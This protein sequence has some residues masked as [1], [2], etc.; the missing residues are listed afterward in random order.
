MDVDVLQQFDE[1]RMKKPS[2]MS[3]LLTIHTEKPDGTKVTINIE[4]DEDARRYREIQALEQSA[5]DAALSSGGKSFADK[6]VSKLIQDYL[7]EY[8]DSW[9][10]TVYQEYP[11]ELG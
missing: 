5:T 6:P 8:K 3:D 1:L 2:F 11:P 4:N 7:S 10:P 9:E